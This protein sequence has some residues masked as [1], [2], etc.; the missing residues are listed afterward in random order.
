MFYENKTEKLITHE[1]WVARVWRAVRLAG[2]V[3]GVSLAI[4]M[5]GYHMLG[6][7]NWVDAF[8]EAAMI[9][10]GMGAVAPMTNDAVKIFAGIYSL[11]CGFAVLSTYGIIIAPFLHRLLHKFHVPEK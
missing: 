9:L 6:G 10:G 3:V 7:L 2:V 5:V 4:G 1:K 8:L 11:Y